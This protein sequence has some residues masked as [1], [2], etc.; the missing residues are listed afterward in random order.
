M[1]TQ[2]VLSD[3]YADL[4]RY[5]HGVI[6]PATG[7]DRLGKAARIVAR[8][9]AVPMRA[10]DD[11]A[12]YATLRDRVLRR[13]L[14]TMPR[15]WWPLSRTV[16]VD[17]ELAEQPGATQ[18]VRAILLLH[19]IDGLT[20]DEAE[21]VVSRLGRRSEGVR[22]AARTAEGLLAEASPA[23][24][25][26][27]AAQVT[28]PSI[29]GVRMPWLVGV[30]TLLIAA[31]VGAGVPLLVSG[32]SNDED[33]YLGVPLTTAIDSTGP[34]CFFGWPSRG[35]ALPGADE[36]PA[37][38]PMIRRAVL[39][40]KR[41]YP[42]G[43]QRL[44]RYDRDTDQA[45]RVL[46][47]GQTASGERAVL[48]CQ[49]QNIARYVESDSLEDGYDLN[50]GV[51]PDLDLTSEHPQRVPFI[52]LGAAWLV[53][54]DATRL[55]VG[56]TTGDPNWRTDSPDKHGLVPDRTL[57]LPTTSCRSDNDERPVI[58]RVEVAE[59]PKYLRPVLPKAKSPTLL[60]AVHS[61]EE[62]DDGPMT[63][64]PSMA[65]DIGTTDTELQALRSL[66]CAGELD[67]FRTEEEAY[68]EIA[69]LEVLDSVDLPGSGTQQAFQAQMYVRWGSGSI[70]DV[71]VAGLTREGGND[72]Y[73]ELGDLGRRTPAGAAGW[74]PGSDNYWY[75]VVVGDEDT[76]RVRVVGDLSDTVT[77][78]SVVLKGPRITNG[79][80][81]PQ[82][83]VAVALEDRHGR[84]LKASS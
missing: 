12:T 65:S 44:V 38:D 23:D 14:R 75:Y 77:G 33:D 1:S 4:L 47:A 55:Q 56:A 57:E 66:V 21:Q 63:L 81:P 64:L 8:A 19:Q 5:A 27:I 52:D 80:N 53:D 40:W 82:L 41:D 30:A 31:L 7:A 18:S 43:E 26:P 54:P 68:V 20:I 51:L 36:D 46:Y 50:V 13:A 48:L 15:R 70:S 37:D 25:G 2:Q 67:V 39:A 49:G 58:V 73:D 35:D 62:S 10:E 72:G 34:G 83:P 60:T 61:G 11:D 59:S 3:R 76:A 29:R 71:D 9:A 24:R 45:M 69:W 6:E 22:V 74:W 28:A 84:I 16:A 79:S 17:A 32:I 42:Q 78:Q